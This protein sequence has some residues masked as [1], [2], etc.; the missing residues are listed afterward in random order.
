[1]RN[2]GIDGT[3]T[4][5]SPQDW[6]GRLNPVLPGPLLSKQINRRAV[7]L[8]CLH[9]AIKTTQIGQNIMRIAV[10][11]LD[12]RALLGIINISNYS[13][14]PVLDFHVVGHV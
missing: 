9:A 10:V 13:V 14:H 11:M 4:T 5:H 3:K 2:K 7:L 12:K 1:M 6:S 8:T